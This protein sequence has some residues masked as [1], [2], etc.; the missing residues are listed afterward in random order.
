[1]GALFKAYPEAQPAAMMP[2]ALYTENIPGIASVCDTLRAVYRFEMHSLARQAH[3][4]P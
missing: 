2:R 4:L 3:S 1:M